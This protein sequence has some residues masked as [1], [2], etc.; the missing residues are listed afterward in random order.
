MGPVFST[1]GSAVSDVVHHYERGLEGQWDDALIERLLPVVEDLAAQAE[2]DLRGEGF[3]PHAASFTWQLD[4]G[5]HEEAVSMVEV[6]IKAVAEEV[7]GHLD[8]AVRSAGQHGASTLLI[9][10]STNFSLGNHDVA[11]RTKRVAAAPEEVRPV[12]F[13]GR[14]AGPTPVLIWEAL[15]PGDIVCGPAVINGAT[16]TCPVPRG[17]NMAVDDYGNGRLTRSK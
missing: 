13:D 11:Q 12:R 16:L 10:L 6:R 3:D 2:R 14:A 7:V 4:L 5:E 15:N 17:W 9:R 8:R 1:F